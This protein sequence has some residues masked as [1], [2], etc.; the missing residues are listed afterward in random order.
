MPTLDLRPPQVFTEKMV[1]LSNILHVSQCPVR[2]VAAMKASLAV[3][4]VYE[5]V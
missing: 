2:G 5:G 3:K 4:V 1:P